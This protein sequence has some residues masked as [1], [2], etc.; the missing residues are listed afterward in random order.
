[1]LTITNDLSKISGQ[2]RF[3]KNEELYDLYRSST[4]VRRVYPKVS[5]LAAW[6]ENC[7]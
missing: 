2:F 7:K 5:G 4:V 6:G 3:L 1:M